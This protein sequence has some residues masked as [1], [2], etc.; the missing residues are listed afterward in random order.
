MP[1]TGDGSAL[2]L[3]GISKHFAGVQALAEVRISLQAGQVTAL[4]GENGAGKSTLLRILGG[5][6]APKISISFTSIGGG[7]M[8]KGGGVLRQFAIAGADKKFVWAD[9]R[10]EGD[11]VVVSSDEVPNPLYVRYAWA[12]NPEGANLYNKEGLPASPFRTDHD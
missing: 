1:L 4:L 7:L 10:I 6:Y 12:D 9:A 2:R 5:D 3:E 11:K 8:A